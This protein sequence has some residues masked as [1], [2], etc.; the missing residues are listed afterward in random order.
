MLITSEYASGTIRASI[1][2]TP[3][4]P[5]LLAA[6]IG[7][8][9][10]VTVAFC[11]LLSFASFFLGQAILSGGGAPSASLGSPG[12]LRAV[13]ND[14]RVHCPHG[15]DV[16]RF[17][18]DRAQHGRRRSPPSSAWCSCSRSSCTAFPNPTFATC[19]RTSSPTRS[20]RPSSKGLEGILVTAL[21]DRRVVVDGHLC[22]SR[23]RRRRRSVRAPR[24]LSEAGAERRRMEIHLPAERAEQ[25]KRLSRLIG[26]EP[27]QKRT[28]AELGFFLVSSALACIVVLALAALGFVGLVLTF[29]LV[30]VLVLAGGL[31]AARGLGAGRCCTSRVMSACRSSASR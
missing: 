14:R 25:V 15:A 21:S 26:R 4:R 11:E 7:V 17:R 30:G 16:V 1:A 5:M 6:K 18:V 29:V 20:C 27:F 10:A 12:A 23:P 13:V 19:R 3:R 31:R 24:R 8:A 9:A 28:W 22:R 2:A